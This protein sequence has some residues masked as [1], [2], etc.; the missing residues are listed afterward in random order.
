[1]KWRTFGATWWGRAWIDALEH[2]ARLVPN[3]LP[4]G[5]PYARQ[6]RTGEL[7]V[8]HGSVTAPVRGSRRQPYQVTLRV[9]TFDDEEWD[10]LL[11]AIA[12]RA[13]HAAALLDGGLAPAVGDDARA[14]GIELLPDAGELQPR[15]SCPDW[16]DPCKHAA[17][18]CYLV[19]DALDTDP[20]A[21]FELR[22]RDRDRVLAGIRRRRSGSDATASPATELD[23]MADTPDPG[24]RATVAWARP[25]GD[26][27]RLPAPTGAPGRPAP[28]PTDPPEDSGFDA[29]GL[30]ALADDAAR[31]AWLV[32]RGEAGSGLGLAEDA[33]L[34]RR[35]A[36]ALGTPRWGGLATRSGL[37]AATP[38]GRALA[39]RRGGAEGLGPLDEEPWRPP[40]TTMA[41]A[42]DSVAAVG[43]SRVRVD[44]NRLVLDDV[45]QLRL[46]RRGRWARFEKRRGR[47]E[48]AAPLA[49]EP[50]D[51]IDDPTDP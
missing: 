35:G 22:G 19:A 51:L 21:L 17:G 40:P 30:I 46:G 27:P 18:V 34:A 4:R 8:G 15:C 1:M 11:G 28:W 7:S 49:E 33:E 50:D 42:R 6:D 39:W 10:R 2:R 45:I 9:R 31:R 47:W 20:F 26:L 25:L 44:R 37:R 13:G 5:R 41:A 12:G 14:V 23:D 29:A 38:A 16:A 48:L 43:P 3:R 32:R 36:A 24:V